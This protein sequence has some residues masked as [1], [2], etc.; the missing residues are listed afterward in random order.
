M[1]RDRLLATRLLTHK[2]SDPVYYVI[3]RLPPT[4]KPLNKLCRL[5]ANA[6]L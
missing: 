4:K 1:K 5:L 3:G 2:A 6:G